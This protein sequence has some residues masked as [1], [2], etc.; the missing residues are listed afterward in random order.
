MTTLL[1]PPEARPRNLNSGAAASRAWGFSTDTLRKINSQRTYR[2]CLRKF[3]LK[4]M[5]VATPHCGGRGHSERHHWWQAPRN[6]KL[7]SDITRAD[8]RRHGDRDS[9]FSMSD[10]EFEL[11][12]I[13]QRASILRASAACSS[14]GSRRLSHCCSPASSW[15]LRRL[16]SPTS[17]LKLHTLLRTTPTGLLPLFNKHSNADTNTPQGPLLILA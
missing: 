2:L 13:A 14:S 10:R 12:V 4:A 1:E 5:P 16:L 11:R 15:R 17:P 7:K 9:Q 6:F 8:R 3:D